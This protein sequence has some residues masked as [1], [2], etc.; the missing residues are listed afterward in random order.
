MTPNEIRTTLLSQKQRV[1]EAAQGWTVVS[2]SPDN[3]LTAMAALLVPNCSLATGSIAELLAELP[4][5]LEQ[6]LVICD[7][8]LPDG[9]VVELM[10]QL[11]EARP[12]ATC[13]FLVYLPK[14]TAQPRLEQLL[15][16]GCDALCCRSSGGSGAVL[17]A[18]VQALN[19]MQSVDGAF[20]RR[21]QR[22]HRSDEQP[23]LSSSELEL[24]HLL[25]RGH[26]GPQI[27]ALRQR[28]CD[29]IRR[30]LSVIYRKT[31]VRDQR[32]LIAWALAHGVIRPLDLERSTS[33]Q[34]PGMKTCVAGGNKRGIR[35]THH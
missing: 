14:S 22:S 20:R 5:E 8:E 35:P 24:I 33:A 27:A 21:L 19:G 3:E 10:R 34:E 13:R 28:R 25:A 7:D 4:N 12:Q 30:Q 18:L 2:C 1:A 32:G 11:R 9:G 17:S 31:G 6:L 26:N 29:S 16:H 23:E 15:A